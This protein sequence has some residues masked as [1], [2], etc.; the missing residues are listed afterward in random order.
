MLITAI[1]KLKGTTYALYVDGEKAFNI[2]LET[3]MSEHLKVGI[4]ISC[5]RLNEINNAVLTRKAR[6]RALYLLSYRDHSRKQLFDKLK[7]TSSDEIADVIC[8]KMEEIGLLDDEVYANK[9]AHHLFGV[10]KQ[11]EI[12]VRFELKKAGI[13]D[14]LIEDALS[15][16][17]PDATHTILAIIAKKYKNK[18]DNS[19]NIKKTIA[20]LMRQG[21]CYDDVKSAVNRYISDG[22]IDD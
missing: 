18:L 20:S 17:A 9:L 22:G 19:D 10:K 2:D 8:D 15:N 1:E 16:N 6:E 12:K 14:Y 4:D 21:F 7:R 3:V 11:S 13:S 5:E